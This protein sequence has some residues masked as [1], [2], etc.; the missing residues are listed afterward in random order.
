MIQKVEKGDI[1]IKDA[2]VLRGLMEKNYAPLLIDV[3]CWVASEYG[4]VLTES[5]REQ[6]HKND[7]HGTWP[8]R[9]N[10]LRTWC[11]VEENKAKG[12]EEA[13]N[14]RWAYDPNR[15]G[16]NVAWIHQNRNAQGVHFHIQVHPNTVLR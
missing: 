6:L 9:A 8:V 4:F 13:I 1:V 3:I 16:M 12:I 5:Y 10:D 7:L 11:Y 2:S 14:D 15:P